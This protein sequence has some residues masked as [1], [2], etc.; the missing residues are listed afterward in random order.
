MSSNK[1]FKFM[2]NYF[3]KKHSSVKNNQKFILKFIIYT[4]VFFYYF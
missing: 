2:I 4:Y 3:K 1:N